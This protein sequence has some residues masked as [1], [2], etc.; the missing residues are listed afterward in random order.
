MARRLPPGLILQKCIDTAQKML[1][2][3]TQ[4][5]LTPSQARAE[6][7]MLAQ[8]CSLSPVFSSTSTSTS[9][10]TQSELETCTVKEQD[11]QVFIKLI[12]RRSS[13]E[14]M[15]Y[16]TGEQEFWSLML[17]VN[18][19]T[20]IPRPDT[21]TLVDSLLK[22]T[23]DPFSHSKVLDLYTGAAP[24]L[25]AALTE[26]PNATGVGI[27]ISD[28][29]V[30]VAR[31]N[32]ARHDLSH[33]TLFQ[34]EDLHDMGWTSEVDWD[35]VF[36]NPPYIP[37][38][39]MNKLMPDV[40]KYEPTLALVGGDTDG[41]EPY[42][43]LAESVEEGRLKFVGKESV[44]ILEVGQHQDIDVVEI[45]QNVAQMKV[46]EVRKDLNNVARSVVLCPLDV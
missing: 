26:M 15:S 2:S 10:L 29:A 11:F 30:E 20:L 18:R 6:T 42:R 32:A 45:F 40:R 21:E 17:H 13:A 16:L 24:L 8:Y 7:I 33:R 9:V 19:N 3:S 31:R 35:V 23:I 39:D 34:V 22:C 1:L 43:L 46:R 41:L 38:K 37:L 28:G 27:D 36:A 5:T 44:L 4:L 25:I 14:P 12:E